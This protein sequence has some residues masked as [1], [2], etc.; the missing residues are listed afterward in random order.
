MEF[1]FPMLAAK[2]RGASE[3]EMEDIAATSTRLSTVIKMELDNDD[4]AGAPENT[5]ATHH[6]AGH[7]HQR[8]DHN[9]RPRHKR[10]CVARPGLGKRPQQTWNQQDYVDARLYMQLHSAIDKSS[11]GCTVWN[12]QMG[13]T[14]CFGGVRYPCP[15]IL[16]FF[17]HNET[18][19]WQQ[20]MKVHSKC[21]NSMCVTAQCLQVQLANSQ[22]KSRNDLPPLSRDNKQALIQHWK[23]TG[24]MQHMYTTGISL[25]QVKQIAEQPAKVQQWLSSSYNSI[26]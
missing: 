7:K 18:L 10:I 25:A 19:R 13:K 23:Q 22:G 11:T 17:A 1:V 16:A 5:Q 8:E 21:G 26:G 2:A 20:G 15:Q 14:A 4:E 3:E 12:A 6:S 24:Q 9:E